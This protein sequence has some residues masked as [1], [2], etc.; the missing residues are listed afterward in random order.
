MPGIAYLSILHPH[1]QQIEQAA[2]GLRFISETDSPLLPVQLQ[3]QDVITELLQLSGSVDLPVEKTTLDHFFR[4]AIK[5]F[6]GAP[7]QE[8]ESARRFTGL[9]EILEKNLEGIAV[10]RIGKIQV[11]AFIIG[12]LPDGSYGGLH[13]LLVET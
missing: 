6:P 3:S 2:A 13:T 4:N 7:A 5:S 11:Q 8:V 10:Y 9:K 1:L 12:R